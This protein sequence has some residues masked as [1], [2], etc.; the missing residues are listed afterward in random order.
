[1]LKTRII[2]SIV[3]I[4]IFLTALLLASNTLWAILTLVVMLLGVR[5]WSRLIKLNK[6]QMVGMIISALI[7]SLTLFYTSGIPVVTTLA[8]YHDIFVYNLLGVVTFFWI[9]LAPIWLYTRK[10]V[11]NKFVLS[12]LG[13][14][15]LISVWVALFELRVFSPQVLLSLILTVN[16][17][18]IAAYFVGKNF[19]RNP[20]AS[21]ISPGKT[22][23]GVA[24][25]L[26]GVTLF[27]YLLCIYFNYS[28]WLL[29]GLWLVVIVSII[30]DL[31][32]SLLK[33]QAGV[34]D[35]GRILPGHGGILDR[36]DGLIP[37]LALSLFFIYSPLFANIQ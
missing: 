1:M 18:D 37:S 19:G 24:G 14:L 35:S 27:G 20:L 31:F 3:L 10:T 7:I 30:G 6:G 25:G 22:W 13:L 17:A 32:E 29:I 12:I 23:E 2:T 5:E 36:I 21:Q 34:K 4:G 33:R 16:I 8:P 15:L 9:L 11:T 28:L 26:L